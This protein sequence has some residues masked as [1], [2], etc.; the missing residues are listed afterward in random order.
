MLRSNNA[1]LCILQHA[2]SLKAIHHSVPCAK[3]PLTGFLKLWYAAIVQW[4]TD[5][6]G[7]NQRIKNTKF[8]SI[9]AVTY[10]T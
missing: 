7:T 5:L 9:N 10:E 1:V 3:N 8:P 4:Y 6:V 2:R